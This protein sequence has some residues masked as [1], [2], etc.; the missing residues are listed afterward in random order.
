LVCLIVLAGCANAG[1]GDTVGERA[2]GCLGEDDMIIV[3]LECREILI[4]IENQYLPFNYIL[5]ETNEPSGWDYEA[6]RE[7]CQRLNCIPIY[8][9]IAWDNTIQA[10]ADGQFDVGANGITL[11][12]NRR[13]IVDFSDGYINVEQRLLARMGETRFDDMNAFVANDSLIMGAQN[14]TT[15]FDTALNYLPIGR[16]EPFESFS[17]A[18]GALLARQVDAVIVDEIAGQ[19]YVGEGADQLELVGPSLSTDQL[20]FIFPRGSDLVEP[21]NVAL[22]DMRSDGT[23]DQLATRYFG[24]DFDVTYDDILVIDYSDVNEE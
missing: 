22:A 18:I 12:E 2:P 24:A 14:A 11:T 5:A 13:T 1:S 3:D 16:L 9:N 10:V 23:L 15:N 4:A 17:D 6:W 19:G 21:V 20:G 8:S 7:I